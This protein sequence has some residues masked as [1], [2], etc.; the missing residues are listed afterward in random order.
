MSAADSANDADVIVVGAGPAGSS[1][2]YWLASAGLD[3]AL[4]EK[5]SVPA[6]EGVRR[7]AHP[8]RHAGARRHGHR[9]QREQRLA[10]QPRPARHRRRPAAAPRL[11][12]AHQLPAVRPRPPARRPRRDARHPGRQ[13]RRPAVRAHRRSPSRS[14][15]TPGR[16]VGVEPAR[17]STR[18]RSATARRSCSAARASAASSPSTSACT[19]T[20]SARSASRCAATTPARAR[21][22]TTSSPGSSCG[23]ARP[24]DVAAAARLRLDLRHGRRHGQRRA[25]RAQL[26]RRLPE[27]RLPRDAH[28]LAG[29]HPGGVG[30]A[31]GERHRP[32][33][34]R[35]AA[36][37][38]QPHPALQPRAAARRRL[39]RL[40]QPVQ[41]RGHPL[42]DGVR[43][44][45]PPRRSS[46]RSPARTARAARTRWP[47]T[48]RGCATSGAPTTASAGCS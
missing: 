38:L 15:T 2:A 4:L 10:A 16:V 31:R 22:T 18:G 3:V 36:D 24:N 32:D 33:P 19:A 35:R 34:R 39:R 9:R 12:R 5:T 46:R 48:R 37:G 41:R 6:R 14:S 25:R 7:R 26:Q 29:Q 47:P 13:G 27:D 28:P 30:A 21:T 17:R 23:P 20:T 43:Q 1:A 40:G 42:R 11:A 8:A 45:T 44:A